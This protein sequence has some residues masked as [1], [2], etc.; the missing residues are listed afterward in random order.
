VVYK[1]PILGSTE[2]SSFF[3]ANTTTGLSIAIFKH[4][5]ILDPGTVIVT[6]KLEAG[7]HCLMVTG[8][9]L[10]P[11]LLNCLKDIICVGDNDCKEGSW[12][13]GYRST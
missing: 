3:Y 7:S 8:N 1:S 5:K 9:Y 12:Y 13:R 11:K 10:A 4:I 6:K 2:E